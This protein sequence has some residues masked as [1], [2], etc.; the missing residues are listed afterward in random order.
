LI[1]ASTAFSPARS[2][3]D[4]ALGENNAVVFLADG[5]VNEVLEFGVIAVAQE[6]ADFKPSFLPS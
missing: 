4:R 1:P 2:S 5:L 3:T 6:G